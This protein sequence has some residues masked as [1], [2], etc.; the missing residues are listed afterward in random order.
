MKK[1]SD[2]LSKHQRRTLRLKTAQ[3]A[4]DQ[5]LGSLSQLDALK[6]ENKKLLEQRGKLAA[7]LQEWVRE[8]AEAGDING[9]T[10]IKARIFVWTK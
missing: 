8:K 1:R 5:R 10:A 6:D 2:H 9:A 3:R 7:L 4:V